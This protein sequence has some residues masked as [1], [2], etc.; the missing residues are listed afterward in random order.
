MLIRMQILSMTKRAGMWIECTQ[1]RKKILNKMD[2]V[3][4]EVLVLL[5]WNLHSLIFHPKHMQF[6]QHVPQ[7]WSKAKVSEDVKAKLHN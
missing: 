4:K 7:I 6:L 1:E 5:L 2:R 3:G